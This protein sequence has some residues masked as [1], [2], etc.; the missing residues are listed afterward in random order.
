MRRCP[1]FTSS[2]TVDSTFTTSNNVLEI[3]NPT[4]GESGS[5]LQTRDIAANRRLRFAQDLQYEFLNGPAV[6]LFRHVNNTSEEQH[7]GGSLQE[8]YN[9]CW[10]GGSTL[11][12]AL[13]H[14]VRA[15][16]RPCWDT[17]HGNWKFIE[18]RLTAQLDL[19]SHSKVIILL[20]HWLFRGYETRKLS[21]AWSLFSPDI[22]NNWNTNR[23]N[24]LG[25][26][27]LKLSYFIG[28]VG[29]KESNA[30]SKILQRRM[31]SIEP[32]PTYWWF[33]IQQSWWGVM[34]K[35][36]IIGSTG[37]GLRLLF[38][39]KTEDERCI[40]M[41]HMRNES[42]VSCWVASSVGINIWRVMC[43]SR[44]ESVIQ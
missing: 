14:Q 41:F 21:K 3:L 15:L 1:S 38:C 2:T 13:L 17:V 29:S 35:E 27:G 33:L 18:T 16:P 32:P 39:S 24:C 34:K 30:D 28:H 6:S 26:L 5:L 25:C 40:P 36:R 4:R 7:G 19:V 8:L 43:I 37:C 10:Y 42:D 11:E 20:P 44:E 31:T 22:L 12:T 23:S 9:G